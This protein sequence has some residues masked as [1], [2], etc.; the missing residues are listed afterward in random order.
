MGLRDLSFVEV[1]DERL[2]SLWNVRESGLYVRDNATGRR[3]ADD[4][5]RMMLRLDNPVLLGQ[6]GRAM[7]VQGNFGGIEIG[8]AQR[9]AEHLLTRL[10]V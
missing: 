2:K 6:I 8:F 7:V 9:I 10:A 4:C 1:E 5:I 3:Y